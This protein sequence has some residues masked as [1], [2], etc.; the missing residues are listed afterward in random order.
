MRFRG[1]IND[2]RI[3]W[4]RES[5]PQ[6]L[7]QYKVGHMIERKRSLQS[8]LRQLARTEYGAGVVD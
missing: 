2:A 5:L 3:S 7:G 8:I 1:C 4:C 6:P